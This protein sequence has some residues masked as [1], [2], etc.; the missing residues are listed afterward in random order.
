MVVFQYYTEIVSMSING[1]SPASL[2]TQLVTRDFFPGFVIQK[3]CLLNTWSEQSHFQYYRFLYYCVKICLCFG[4]FT[5]HN[6][7]WNVFD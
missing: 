5:E 6:F 3:L 4:N 7:F 2:L 1:T